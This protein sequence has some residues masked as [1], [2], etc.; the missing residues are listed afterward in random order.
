MNQ[1]KR[2]I[3]D[4]RSSE[5]AAE[6][7]GDIDLL[8]QLKEERLLL[9]L[10]VV[11]FAKK[12]DKKEIIFKPQKIKDIKAVS[13]EKIG[14]DYIP[15][16]KGAYNVLAGSGGCVDMDTEFLTRN[17]WVKISEY[18]N[19]EICEWNEDGSTTF[20]KPFKYIKIKEDYLT[21]LK[22]NTI[23]MMI[24]DEHRFPYLSKG[25]KVKVDYFKNIKMFSSVAIPR[26]FSTPDNTEGVNISDD[27]IRVLVMQSADGNIDKKSKK[28]RIRINVKKDRKKTRVI[29]LLENAKIDYKIYN[30]NINDG[31][32]KLAYYPPKEISFRGLEVLWGCNHSQLILI[33]D[34]CRYWDGSSVERKNVTTLSFS[35]NKKDCDLIQYAFSSTAGKYCGISKDIREYKKESIY[36][37]SLSS[38]NKSVIE[39]KGSKKHKPINQE[40][41]KTK[42]GFKYC[43]T[44]STGFW[45]ARRNGKIFPTGNCGKSAIALKSLLLWLK[46]NPKKQ[47]LAFFT[48]D[49]RDEIVSRAEMICSNSNLNL[50]L[51]NRI[52]FICLDNDDR[53]KWVESGKNGYKIREDYISSII[54]YCLDNSVEYIILDPLK[55]FHRLSEN[56]NDDMD[57]LVRDV[58]TKIAVDTKAVV[59]VLHHSSKGEHGGARGASTITDSARVAWQ[60]G[61]YF[62]KGSDGKLTENLEKKG[63]IKLEIIKDNMGIEQLC[64]IRNKEDKSI[65]NPLFS[66]GFNDSP[67]ETEFESEPYMP[68]I[69]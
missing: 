25:K 14:L 29:E 48:E 9:E 2:K 28:F 58:F 33:A 59:L 35:G 7:R 44:T 67:I 10:E 45:L 18:D 41:V 11:R 4:L 49:G 6:S 46:C 55:R 51:V 15:L 36:K 31:Y 53:I 42:D 23:D 32:L 52:N 26:N 5:I 12:T 60:I 17:G 56:S 16:I 69:F 34:E 61:R 40:I 30:N 19:Q 37:V 8:I 54:D 21:H 27:L 43:F 50:D 20:R 47:G 57:I 3:Q 1:T 63:K 66:G 62:I 38:R 68:D 65:D 13:M 24:C 22:S 64:R 39:F